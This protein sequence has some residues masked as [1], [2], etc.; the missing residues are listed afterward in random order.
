M[1]LSLKATTPETIS[2]DEDIL[3]IEWKDG[4]VSEF[5]LLELRKR[6][7]C[8]V[9]RGGHGGKIG[10]STGQIKEAK[11]L[12]FSKVGRY[13][14]NLVWGDYHNTGIYSF[15]SLRLFWQGE[16]GDLGLPG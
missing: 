10:A 11:L 9:C 8:V 6:C 1:A 15:D 12:S 2:F 13:A 7:P 16:E 14:V 3:K 5:S 4:V